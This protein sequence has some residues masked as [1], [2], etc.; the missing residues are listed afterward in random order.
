MNTIKVSIPITVE[1]DIAAWNEEYGCDS[2]AEVRADVKTHIAN[3]VNQ[4]L[5]ALG[6]LA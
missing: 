1:I 2:A 4:Q 6:V 3:M 5:D